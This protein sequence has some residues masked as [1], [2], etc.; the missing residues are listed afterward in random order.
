MKL[1]THRFNNRFWWLRLIRC[2]HVLMLALL[3]SIAFNCWQV[4]CVAW[5]KW[6]YD[7][8]QRHNAKLKYAL[9]TSEN[10]CEDLAGQL[11]RCE[12]Q[13]VALEMPPGLEVGRY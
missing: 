2:R 1:E 13:P 7:E 6:C 10:E 5:Y 11:E 9:Q 8:A 12:S 3:V 4:G